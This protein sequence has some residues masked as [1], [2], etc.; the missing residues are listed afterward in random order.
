MNDRAAMLRMARWLAVGW[1]CAI[2]P[3]TLTAAAILDRRLTAA[4]R[5]DLHQLNATGVV[6]TF[7]FVSAA[8][9]GVVLIMR[10]PGHPVGWIFLAL[11][12]DLAAAAVGQSY[13]LAGAVARPG[14]LPWAAPV[15]VVADSQFVVW[16]VLLGAALHLTPTGRALSRRW[17]WV[18][19]VT[20]VSACVWFAMK[21]FSDE[22]LN[23]PLQAVAGPWAQRF[24]LP[25]RVVYLIAV[26]VTNVGVVLSAVSV[27][28]RVK[29]SRGVERR[30]LKWMLV[31]AIVFPLLVIA[32]FVAA[33]TDHPAVLNI[34]AALF[35][36]VVPVAAGLSVV[37]YRLYDVDR[38][39][40]RAAA[41]VVVS[42]LL[43][44]VFV[45]IVAA[46]RSLLGGVDSESSAAGLVASVVTVAMAAPVY[47]R[48]QRM[49]DR[50]FNRRQY[51]ALNMVRDF[52]RDPTPQA[53]VEHVFQA[54]TGDST[55]R[56]AYRV[57]DSTQWVSATGHTVP[58]DQSDLVVLRQQ[59]PVARIHFDA[60]TVERELVNSMAREATAEL[61]NV[62]LRAAVALQLVEVQE[63]RAR[64]VA[65]H[66][67][68]RHRLE[69][70]LHDGAQQRLL[71]MAFEMRAAELSGDAVRI[72][73]TLG[74]AV[75]QLRTAVEELRDLANGLR[76]EMLSDG[77]LA[78]ALEDLAS[79]TT[80]PVHVHSTSDRFEPDVEAALW[81]IACEAITNAVKHAD[82]SWIEVSVERIDNTVRLAVNDNGVGGADSSGTGLR[83]LADRAEAGGGRLTVTGRA[84]RGTTIT[85]ELPC[86]S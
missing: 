14:S 44:G 83:G 78:A 9:V 72:G 35:V 12:T 47:R 30:Q 29:R 54:A 25:L 46:L 57:D 13:A 22:P 65:A 36:I 41:Y 49:L 61:D 56:I 17:Y 39:L 62:G 63:S 40:S 26:V 27:V 69:R 5:A 18:L 32:A 45:G 1:A 79:R 60:E 2:A 59:R 82:S 4:G 58:T 77:G 53:D 75:G 8:A 6:F 19:V 51:S 21:L 48:V 64:I 23:E 80:V 10:R 68:E 74:D 28:V 43:G 11:G 34:A 37:Q 7:A 85:A 84:E 33:T 15:A 55:L 31:V 38:I 76:P 3:V 81:F 16:L 52:V 42:I 24:P 20:I 70:N 73:A 50:R 86:A 71:G 66:L 67:S